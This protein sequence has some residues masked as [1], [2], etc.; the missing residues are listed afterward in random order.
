[1][2]VDIWIERIQLPFVSLKM[3][4]VEITDEDC[5]SSIVRILVYC[6]S[7]NAEW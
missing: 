5:F 3:L 1:M 4:S 2:D 6:R 7:T